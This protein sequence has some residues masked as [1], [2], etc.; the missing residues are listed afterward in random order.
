MLPN[1]GQ[2]VTKNELSSCNQKT[3]L[4]AHM[5]GKYINTAFHCVYSKFEHA[6]VDP[7]TPPSPPSPLSSSPVSPMN[8]A[9][10]SHPLNLLLRFK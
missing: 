2:Q 8:L 3:L 7:A 4:G 10:D 1:I 9:V 5:M 6:V